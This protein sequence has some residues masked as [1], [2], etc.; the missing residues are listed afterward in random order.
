GEVAPATLVTP[1]WKPARRGSRTA[2]ESATLKPAGKVLG[3]WGLSAT[4]AAAV[5]GVVVPGWL[6]RDRWPP[7]RQRENADTGQADPLTSTQPNVLDQRPPEHIPRH[8]LALAGLAA[9]DPA[10]PELVAVLGDSRLSL[11]SDTPGGIA[12]SPTGH[13]LAVAG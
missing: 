9:Q 11:F 13:L 6:M 1:A 2:N 12:T 7:S 5:A 4:L 10:P 8:L 3:A